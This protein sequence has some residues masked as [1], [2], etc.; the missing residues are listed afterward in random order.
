MNRNFLRT[1]FP[2]L[3]AAAVSAR[4]ALAPDPDNGGLILP[5]GFRAVVAADNLMAG[6]SGDA[7][8]FLAVAPNGDVYA[9][10]SAGGIFALRDDNGDGRFEEHQEFGRGGGTGIAVRDG[11]I[12]SS[13]NSSVVRYR[14]EAD[15]LVPSGEPEVVVTGLP[16]EGQHNAKSFAFDGEGRL[17]V[18]V[19]SPANAYSDGDRERGARGKDATEFLRTH[20]G[21]WRF[22]PNRLNQRLADGFHFSTGHRHSLALA[23]QPTAH[24]FY[25]VM[26]GRDNLDTVDPEHYDAL[27]NA[28][29]VAEEMHLLKEGA[30]LGWPYTYWDP[31]KNARMVAPEFGGD[32]H[33]RAPADRYDPPVLAFPAHWAPLQ[34]AFYTGGLFPAKYRGGAFIAFH[35][36]WNR[37]PLPQAG[38][39]VSFV[40]FDAKG[41]PLGTYE[42]FAQGAGGHRF[43]MGGVALAPDGSLYI[44]DTDLG[45]IWRIF[46]TGESAASAA[47]AAT[48]PAA[49]EP[50][51]TAPKVGSARGRSLYVQT[52]AVCHMADGTG[53]GQMQPALAGSKVVAGD[54]AQLIQVLLRGPASVLPADRTK[55]LNVMP[56]FASLSDR[57]AAEVLSY[58]RAAFGGNAPAITADQVA[59]ARGSAGSASGSP[60]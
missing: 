7:L 2:F 33:K 36:S 4:A 20:G 1:L 29:R 53:A 26:M 30:N 49:A 11:W 10:T 43:R 14:R 58:V 3:V 18:E 46:Y 48:A 39:N 5:P 56:A 51:R 60:Q 12:Y 38:F 23:W 28:E 35:G 8:R 54:P 47:P 19:G 22:D 16:D 55:Y 17:L 52:C 45:R 31:I 44:S 37:A 15:E 42:V 40:P 9:K 24:A 50:A 13:T 25:M 57:D 27:D 21:F 32:N 41:A 6:R 59:A 34:M